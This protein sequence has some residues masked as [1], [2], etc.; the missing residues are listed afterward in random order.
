[1]HTTQTSEVREL[2]CD[3]VGAVAGGL[4]PT[5]PGPVPVPYPN[6]GTLEESWAQQW[7]RA[8][9]KARST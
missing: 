9:L 2:T 3:E 6:T 7:V 4:A 8:A 5:G 1:M